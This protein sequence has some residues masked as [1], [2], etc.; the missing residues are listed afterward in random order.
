[1][2]TNKEI[3][4]RHG[5]DYRGDEIDFVLNHARRGESLCLVG[6][7]GSGKSNLI[8]FLRNSEVMGRPLE[9]DDP[10]QL[11]F[12]AVDATGWDGTAESLWRAMLSALLEITTVD[13]P[14]TGISHADPLRRLEAALNWVC[15]THNQQVMFLLD[16]FDEVLRKGP[17]SV[18]DQ[19]SRLRAA[20]NHE[21]LSYLV[22]TRKLPHV[23]GRD[24]ELDSKSKFYDLLR[25]NI[26]AMPLHTREDSMQMLHHL[27][28]V[29]DWPFTDDDLAVIQ[30]QTGNHS[31]LIKITF[32]VCKRR[33]VTPMSDRPRLAD[34]P[35]I[36]DECRRILN[37][38]HHQEREVAIRFA[39][40][41]SLP[42]DESTIDHLKRRELI[43]DAGTWFS[44]L[45]KSYLQG[46]SE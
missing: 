19:F 39:S 6:V 2:T 31:R 42:G 44:P 9:G 10:K 11:C 23:L 22:F 32:E 7:A 34:E 27:N 37:G 21:R 35:E 1:M 30:A 28:A 43:T 17:P 8:I 12:P 4:P 24:H 3:P 26:Y 14:S 36:R 45:M 46:L 25:Y 41:R 38:L 18:F 33:S 13:W 16:E 40:D 20:G 29:A 5:L 15:Q